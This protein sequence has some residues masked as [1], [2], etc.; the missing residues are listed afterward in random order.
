MSERLSK[1]PKSAA[2]FCGGQSSRMGL[3]KAGLVLDDGRTMVEH[4]H[5]ILSGLCESIVFVGHCEGVPKELL[6]TSHHITDEIPGQGPLGGLEAVLS[7]GLDTEYLI[8]PCDLFKV[9][10]ALFELLITDDDENPTVLSS[11]QGI[12]PLIGRYPA[13]LLARVRYQLMEG[14]RSMHQ[15]LDICKTNYVQVPPELIPDLANANSPAD[16][17]EDTN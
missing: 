14:H 7:S 5:S 16:I 1:L 9:S 12:E 8:A 17:P 13:T 15:F 10:S 6:Q 4:V 2:I 3:P 11:V